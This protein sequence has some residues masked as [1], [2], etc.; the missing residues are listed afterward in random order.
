MQRAMSET[1]RR[2]E[3]QLAYNTAHG[4]TPQTV[5]KAI[6]ET[7]EADRNHR[8]AAEAVAERSGDDYEVNEAVFQM[9]SEMREAAVQLDFEAA[10]A[11]RDRILKLK[12][13]WRGAELAPAVAATRKKGRGRAG[14]AGLR[15]S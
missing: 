1:A 6:R 15:R 7:I 3:V 13:A 8:K 2:R 11:I 12:P 10:A 4:I 5:K 14:G 9:E